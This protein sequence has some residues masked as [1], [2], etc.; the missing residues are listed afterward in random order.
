[1]AVGGQELLFEE[2]VENIDGIFQL[3]D[4]SGKQ[5]IE[6]PVSLY[7]LTVAE[8][9]YNRLTAAMESIQTTS[10]NIQD[11][12]L[13]CAEDADG[14]NMVRDA[15]TLALN[16]NPDFFYV[17]GGFSYM[18]TGSYI[19]VSVTL[20]YVD[21]SRAAILALRQ[22][23]ENELRK[24]LNTAVPPSQ[25]ATMTQTELALALHDII[26]LQSR[27][28]T[29]ALDILDAGGT[30]RD[31]YPNMYNA[32]GT[33]VEKHAVC[34]SYALAYMDLLK[35]V[36]I[37]SKYVSSAAMNHGWNLV[38]I[39]D[40]PGE[41]EPVWFHV[42]ATWND[43]IFTASPDNNRDM[44]GYACHRYFMRSDEE[45]TA[46]GTGGDHYGYA[47]DILPAAL[48]PHPNTGFWENVESGMF[49]HDGLWHYNDYTF[50][51]GGFVCGELCTSPYGV[52]LAGSSL[53]DPASYMQRDRNKLY[54]YKQNTYSDR[55]G[56]L[57]YY[58]LE[59][60]TEE[61]LLD[62]EPGY[63]VSELYALNR[64]LTYVAQRINDPAQREL[65]SISLVML[66]DTLYGDAN[67]DDKVD[68]SDALLICNYAAGRL[69]LSSEQL[70]AADVN[71][72]D[73]VML[74][75]SLLIC[76]YV[77]GRFER[78]PVEIT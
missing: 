50:N 78:F 40:L 20:K 5:T 59:T 65:R 19:M 61:R 68:L 70:L 12:A 43:P 35:R 1:M 21:D 30:P 74:D 54:Y 76:N 2:A 42:D 53:S 13:S 23:Y 14:L 29:D 45:I 6:Q 9:L 56:A 47:T 48:L 62:I 49:Y 8:E 22:E 39:E 4:F 46:Y 58:N 31:T 32:Y 75:D 52:D 36:D 18:R 41:S 26:V 69:T 73:R 67:G 3:G 44:S 38:K 33:V 63:Y 28:N 25:R 55:N 27:Y 17:Q 57:Y 16:N 72:D 11:L 37:V 34:Q 66:G 64:N 71:G 15:F 51:Q 7:A 10:I 77:A 24:M 60:K